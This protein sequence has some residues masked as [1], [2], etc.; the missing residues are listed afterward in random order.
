MLILRELG[1]EEGGQLSVAVRQWAL[2]V[3]L[4]LQF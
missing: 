4:C 3:D 1:G 2:W